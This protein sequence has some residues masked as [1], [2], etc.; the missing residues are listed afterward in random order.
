MTVILKNNAFG[1]LVSSISASDTAIVLQSG[2]GANF[3]TLGSGEYFYATLQPTS[4]V[5]E[6][7]KVVARTGDVLTV[8]RAQEGTSAVSFAA[9]SRVELRVTAKSV[10]DAIEDRVNVPKPASDITFTPYANIAATNVQAAIQEEVNDLAGTAGST[11][12]GYLPG[13]TGGVL[14]TIQAQLR[15]SV[16]VLDFMTNAQRTDVL[17]GTGSVDVTAAITAAIEASCAGYGQ[18]P[19]IL[20]WPNGTYYVAS[21]PTTM[22]SNVTFVFEPGVVI[23]YDVADPTSSPLFGAY[24]Q[25]NLTFIGNGA[26]INGKNTGGTSEGNGNAFDFY[27]CDNVHVENLN[28]NNF[29]TDGITLTGDATGSGP[30]RNVTL[31]DLKIAGSRRNNLSI[32][33]VIGCRVI[34]GEYNGAGNPANRNAAGPWAGIDIEP[35][36]D[37]WLEDLVL[38]GVNTTGNAGAGIQTTVGAL[39]ST[40]IGGETVGVTILG[41]QS[42][43]D[44]TANGYIAA[45]WFISGGGAQKLKGQIVVRDYIVNEP[46]ASGVRFMRWDADNAVKVTLDNVRVIDPD[47]GNDTSYAI[48]DRC[49]FVLAIVAADSETTLGNIELR[50]CSVTDTRPP[51]SG[52][53]QYGMLLSADAGK[54]LKNI[55][56][57]DPKTTGDYAAGVKADAN[58]FGHASMANVDVVYSSPEPLS[59]STSSTVYAQAVGKRLLAT[60]A[61]NFTLPTAAT[62][63]GAHYEVQCAA[64]IDS[65]SLVPAAGDTIQYY[66]ASAGQQIVLDTGATCRIRSQGGTSW[67]VEL[68]TGAWRR[69]GSNVS[70]TKVTNW[71]STAAP[72]SGTWGQGDVVFNAT[73]TQGIN[74]GWVCTVAGTPGTWFPFGQSGVFGSI[75]G[76]PSFA[77]QIAV[78]AGEAYI[79][80]AA[81]SSADWKKITP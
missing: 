26:T 8:T 67:I 44:G 46:V 80:V 28:I 18:R 43:R 42:Y 71:A 53:M 17:N 22:G 77:G 4:G 79:A 31:K 29:W 78:V 33:S 32:I 57:V 69:G 37:C 23:N 38:V 16:S 11:L 50:N 65:V 73:A 7:V 63:N 5:L 52:I 21:K 2:N 76:T 14:T 49:G 68:L 51:G 56:V 9:G 10:T 24:N 54:H 61:L 1:F 47:Y 39:N 66:G 81:S 15:Q 74:A 72:A 3:P 20:Y 35:N 12:V 45:L 30:C 58:V 70:T 48:I 41:G 19:N 6:I 25:S 75:S 60:A 27:G 36:Q 59:I 34:G 13:N 62:Y 40:G 64:G 55:L